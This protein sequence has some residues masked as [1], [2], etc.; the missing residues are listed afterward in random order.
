MFRVYRSLTKWIGMF[1]M[2]MRQLAYSSYLY[3]RPGAN[4]TRIIQQIRNKLRLSAAA[5]QIQIGV[6]DE[7]RGVVDLVQWKAIIFSGD[8]G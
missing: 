3:S 4:P 1:L 7:F 6:E 8:N 2:I 5:V